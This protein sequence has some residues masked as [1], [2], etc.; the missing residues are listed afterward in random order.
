MFLLLPIRSGIELFVNN[1][2]T[3][4]LVLYTRGLNGVFLFLLLVISLNACQFILLLFADLL[5][6]GFIN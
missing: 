3:F 2:N 5:F 1:V 4:K 6:H